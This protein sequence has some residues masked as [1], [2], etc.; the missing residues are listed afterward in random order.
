LQVAPE[1][2]STTPLLDLVDLDQPLQW[3]LVLILFL[4]EDVMKAKDIM[5]RPVISISPLETVETAARLMLDKRISGLPVINPSDRLVGIVTESDFLRRAEIGTERK[6]GKFL[7]FFLGSG[8]LAEEY[9][10]AH[11]RKV[12]DIMTK[13]PVTISED[14]AL[15]ET[16]ALMEKHQIR[17]LPVIKNGR[18]IGIVSR[19]NLLH[20]LANL[21]VDSPRSGVGDYTIRDRILHAYSQQNW[22]AI[23]GLDVIVRDGVVDVWGIILDDRQRSAIIVLAENVPGVKMVRD[24]LTWVDPVSG[25]TLGPD[26]VGASVTN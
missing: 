4:Q 12:S 24:H 10:H 8:T 16:V 26:D 20:A 25:L 22:A 3:A 18:V 5:T 23:G 19:S 13:E 2:V 21:V 17:R 14:T 7:E 9:A 1:L 11:G 6:R 15:D